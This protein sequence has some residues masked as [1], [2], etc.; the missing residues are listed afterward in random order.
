MYLVVITWQKRKTASYVLPAGIYE[1]T[2]L[3]NRWKT[4]SIEKQAIKNK[5]IQDLQEKR[6]HLSQGGLF[7]A[8]ICAIGHFYKSHLYKHI[9][10][11]VVVTCLCLYWH[12]SHSPVHHGRQERYKVGSFA[13]IYLHLF[14]LSLASARHGANPCRTFDGTHPISCNDRPHQR[15]EQERVCHVPFHVRRRRHIGNRSPCLWMDDESF[16]L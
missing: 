4:S 10:R 11:P 1:L 13:D 7:S 15:P 8:L 16:R 3:E 5:S 2:S 6:E 9:C 14:L 12:V